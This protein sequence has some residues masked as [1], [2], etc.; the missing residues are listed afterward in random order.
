MNETVDN[1]NFLKESIHKFKNE[2]QKF[3]SDPE[4]KN[5]NVA[6][7]RQN[8][9][10]IEKKIINKE[11]EIANRVLYD[12][13]STRDF[14]YSHGDTINLPKIKNNYYYPYN[15]LNYKR[16][17]EVETFYL[18]DVEKISALSNTNFGIKKN[19]TGF[20]SM[21]TELKNYFE[22]EKKIFKQNM[23]DR[24]KIKT[25]TLSEIITSRKESFKKN[26][27]KEILIK[28]FEV[29]ANSKKEI[30]SIRNAGNSNFM[31][32][33]KLIKYSS[34][35][36]DYNFQ[37]ITYDEMSRP[38]INETEINKGL[39]NMIY[40][41]IIPKNSDLTPAFNKDGNPLS[42]NKELD[43]FSLYSS[44]DRN[45]NDVGEKIDKTK[46]DFDENKDGLF[47]TNTHGENRSSS[48]SRN[49]SKS[50]NKSSTFSSNRIK[51]VYLNM[52]HKFKTKMN[53]ISDK[54]LNENI[55]LLFS[56]FKIIKNENYKTFQSRHIEKWG[57][58][59]YLIEQLQKILSKLNFSFVEVDGNKLEALSNDEH[60]KLSIKDLIS[61]L[62]YKELKARRLNPINSKQLLMSIKEV[63]IL[64][65]QNN[66][67]IYFARKKL[68]SLRFM[69]N[70]ILK[71]Q[72]SYKLFKGLERSRVML[73]D[74]RSEDMDRFELINFRFKRNWQ[75]IRNRPRIEIHINSISTPV[76]K[77]FTIEKYSEKENNQLSRL[78]S[79][80]DPNVEI[81][82]VSPYKLS[83]EVISY[84]FSIMHSLGVENAK[85]RFHLIVPDSIE[86]FPPGYSL[87]KL[88]HYSSKSISSIR[89]FI[90]EREDSTYIVPGIVS[91]HDIDL[92][93]YLEIPIIMGDL[94]TTEALF[95]KSGAKRVLEIN[96]IPSTP[97][98]WDIN[99]EKD[100]YS[101]LV[102][103][104]T[105]YP[106]INIWIFKI[107]TEF[108]G[109]GIAFIVLD[110]I[111][112]VSELRKDKFDKMITEEK[113]KSEM[114][115]ILRKFLPEKV[116]IVTPRIYKGWNEYFLEFCNMGGIIEACPTFSL[117]LILG[118]PAVSMLIEP[119]GKIQ[120]IC[121]YDKINYSSF[122]NFGAVSPQYSFPEF[123][124]FKII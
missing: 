49:L 115:F 107:N 42:F 8:V 55:I 86:K 95:S 43:L 85:E 99:K 120:T 1:L 57:L 72:S 88:L 24:R 116:E 46:W 62:T 23:I 15:T 111:K 63:A 7:L 92:A 21:N 87:A 80:A 22:E 69:M 20:S 13:N 81:I 38:I 51:E 74:K 94:S 78:I 108:R 36:K 60:K 89:R 75:E 90:K 98:I 29:D 64:K 118:S 110:R 14:Y 96:N 40:R 44:N 41:G 117:G 124:K 123:V 58:F 26:K 4:Y 9:E 79:L 104:L 28:K 66:L 35:S 47:I 113:F 6:N 25:N 32:K 37:P 34:I 59:A 114:N 102:N 27:E 67:R 61:C 112:E 83:N 76:I 121:V 54:H 103:M 50:A 17:P 3:L 73:E 91:K 19:S 82:Y 97:S 109:R 10:E 68:K 2:I 11:K 18:S 5:Y 30:S 100:F 71:I 12:K 70:R 105:N 31:N 122:R 77:N 93:R 39:L 84:Y 65:I 48:Q 16:K 119:D 106:N 33:Q 45:D 56:K 52:E 101:T 53:D